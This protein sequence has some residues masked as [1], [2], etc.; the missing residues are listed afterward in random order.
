MRH[1]QPVLDVEKPGPLAQRETDVR[2]TDLRAF[3]DVQSA[4]DPVRMQRWRPVEVEA[5]DELHK[6]EAVTLDFPCTEVSAPTGGG[7]GDVVSRSFLDLFD[8]QEYQ[9]TAVRSLAAPRSATRS[10]GLKMIAAL[11]PEGV[12]VLPQVEASVA[13]FSRDSMFADRPRIDAIEWIARHDRRKA[14]ALANG[15][16]LDER[17]GAQ[18]RFRRLVLFLKSLGKDAAPATDGLKRAA[19]DKRNA[20]LAATAANL[21]KSLAP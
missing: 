20:R 11:G 7:F 16:L 2:S 3:R 6:V 8:R 10:S 19:A 13:T 12:Q 15:L 4:G 9:D 21:L 14:A 18:G 1:D 17:W 5:A